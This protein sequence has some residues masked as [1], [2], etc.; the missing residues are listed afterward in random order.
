MSNASTAIC[1]AKRHR[2]VSNATTTGVIPTFTSNQRPLRRKRSAKKRWKDARSKRLA[3]TAQS[4]SRFFARS[5]RK[6]AARKREGRAQ[7]EKRGSSV[8]ETGNVIE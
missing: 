7:K 2:P 6:M 5:F 1:V 3:T 4:Y 8:L